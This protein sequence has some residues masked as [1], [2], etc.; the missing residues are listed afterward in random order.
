VGRAPTLE[1]LLVFYLPD[2]DE[3]REAIDRISKSAFKRMK[4]FNPYWEGGGQTYEDLD[5]YRVVLVN[6]ESPF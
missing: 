5:G 6:A 1:N 3:Y 4:S 2:D